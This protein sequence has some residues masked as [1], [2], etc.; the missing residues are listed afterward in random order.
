[1]KGRMMTIAADGTMVVEQLDRAPS[2]ERLQ[3]IVGGYVEQVPA[4]D[5]VEEDGVRTR[6]VAFCNEEGKLEGLPANTVATKMWLKSAA[7][8]GVPVHDM[9]C[10]TVVVL[11]GDADFMSA[12]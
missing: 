9:L 8:V 10:G 6:V 2:L 4:F 11:S 5:I 3:R 1:M 7:R 12:L